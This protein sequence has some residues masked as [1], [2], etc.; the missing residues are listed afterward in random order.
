[1]RIGIA[2]LPFM[3]G[4]LIP[5][6]AQQPHIIF[7]AAASLTDVLTE[8]QPRAE[9]FLGARVLFNFAGSGT[10]CRQIE[11]GAP[12]DV[13]FTA[14]AE[15]MDRLEKSGLVISAS[16]RDVLSNS[17]VLIGDTGLAP[18]AGIDELRTLLSRAEF[19]AIGNPDVVPAGRYAVQALTTCGLYSLVEKK[20]VLGGTVREVLQYVESGSAPVGIVFLTD[21]LSVKPGSHLRRLFLFSED[22]LKTPILYPIAVVSATRNRDIAGKMIDFLLSDVARNAF[23]RAGF[24]LK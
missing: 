21:A 4:T 6:F 12:V 19:L 18:A 20:L 16:R 24:I 7:S 10:L 2:L 8:L 1:M 13:V 17:M 15:D 22:A 3:L 14:A 5:C 11:E 23:R 9:A